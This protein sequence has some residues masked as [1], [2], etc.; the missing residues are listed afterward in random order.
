[1]KYITYIMLMFTL[2]ACGKGVE[3]QSVKDEMINLFSYCVSHSN[4][5][6]EAIDSCLT[7]AKELQ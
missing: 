6:K 4:G 5:S 1:M 2:T 7:S 3:P